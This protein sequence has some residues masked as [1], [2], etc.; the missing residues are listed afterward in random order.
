[1]KKE[2][3]FDENTKIYKLSVEQAR[4]VLWA[5]LRTERE[6][7]K[8]VSFGKIELDF[9]QCSVERTLRHVIKE[10]ANGSVGDE[11]RNLWFMRLGYY[12]GESLKRANPK[13][14]WG[15]GDAQ[16]AF[17]NHPVI[18]GFAKGEEAE[19]INISRNIVMAV[20]EGISP[21][22]RISI[23]VTFWFDAARA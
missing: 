8:S 6:A 15:L 9:S 13:L 22:N 23:A 10:I 17:A 11:Q 1:M 12:F 16:Y 20:A 7:F 4:E 18:T 19:L 3:V 2:S 14:E 5:F 21:D